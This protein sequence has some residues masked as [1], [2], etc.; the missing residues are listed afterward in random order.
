M[1]YLWHP[2]TKYVYLKMFCLKW[3]IFCIFR[4]EKLQQ[5]NLC[6][7]E[8]KSLAS[9]PTFYGCILQAR[10]SLAQLLL[11]PTK[12]NTNQ[13]SSCLQITCVDFVVELSWINLHSFNFNCGKF[14]GSIGSRNSYYETKL[15]ETTHLL[16]QRLHRE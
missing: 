13:L 5:C 12:I 16:T 15:E 3:N 2:R 1:T 10:Q 11:F 14:L 7:E 6:S 4:A 8:H 9:P